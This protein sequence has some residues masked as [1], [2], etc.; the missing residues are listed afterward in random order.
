M[1]IVRLALR[2]P[3]TFVGMAL[4]IILL[5]PV[6]LLRTPVDIFP[7]I[8]ILVISLVWTYTG[9]QPQEMEQR[10]TSNVERGIQTLVNDVEHI[11]S[12]SFN[13]IAVIKVFF[14]PGANIQTSLAQATAISQTFLRFLPPGT[15]PPLV[16]IYSASTVP[17]IQIGL[18]SDTLS[19]QQLFDFG[20]YFIRTQL[21]AVPGA[22]TPFP[23]GGKQRVISVDINPTELQAKGLSAVDIVNAVSAQNLILPTGTAKLG[24]LEYNVEM[25]GSPQSVAELNDLPVK[26]VNG[27]TIYMREVAHV[28]DGFSPQTNIVRANGQRG[29]LMAVYKTGGASTLDIVTRVKQTLLNYAGSLPESLHMTM[30][31]D[32]SL[33]V[34]ASIQGVLREALIAACLTALMILLFLG[35]WKS[36]LIIAIS[37]PLSIL[38]SILLLSA[39]GETINIMTL[40]GLALAVGILVDDAK[41]EIEN[42]T[43]NLGMGKEGVKA[44]LDGAQQI[45][46]PALVSTLCICIVFIPMFF[47]SGVARFLFVPLAEAVSFAMLASYMWSRTIVPTLA[48]YLLSSE[49]EYHADEHAGEKT[50]FFRRYQ[51]GFERSF[52][53]FREGYRGALGA[54]LRSPRLFSICFLAFCGF[55]VLLVGVLGRDFFPKVDAGQIRLHMRARTGLRI[56]ETARLADQVN[57]VIRETIPK[58]ELTTVLD[59]IGL[60][61]HRIK[62]T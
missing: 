14:Q 60:S 6:V 17:V 1:W 20:N 29:S 22:A 26:T 27:A 34:R 4:A 8:N 56:E 44:I 45:A 42:L 48:M 10:I 35:N 33:F 28:R 30:L 13:G 16:I 53:K 18:T 32:Q 59:N 51:Q 46:V 37:I 15:T 39:L 61:S 55:S 54:A 25:N 19:E 50:G 47:L 31:F 3:Y 11:E 7:E 43:R 40:G 38:V 62:P 58:D 9:L 21:A 36:T 41:G 2:R 52:E 49:D 12:Q 24:T 23:Y 5:T 57:G